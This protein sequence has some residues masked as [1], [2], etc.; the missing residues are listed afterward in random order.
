MS[1]IPPHKAT[2]PSLQSLPLIPT[3]YTIQKRERR[4]EEG[5]REEKKEKRG[6]APHTGAPPE[7]AVGELPHHHHALI[8]LELKEKATPS[9]VFFLELPWRPQDDLRPRARPS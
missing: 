9:F 8:S 5:K 7:D 2:N 3:H 6:G 4:E 1:A